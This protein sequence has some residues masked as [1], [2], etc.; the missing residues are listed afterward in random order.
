MIKTNN[1][2]HKKLIYYY[3]IGQN[4]NLINKMMN[5]KIMNIDCNK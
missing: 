4:N 3:I 5:L 1:Y 2:Q